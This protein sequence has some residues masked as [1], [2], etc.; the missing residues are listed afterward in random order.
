MSFS[1]TLVWILMLLSPSK[2]GVFTLQ[3]ALTF[4]PSP[5]RYMWSLSLYCICCWSSSQRLF[6]YWLNHSLP[7]TALLAPQSRSVALHVSD[8]RNFSSGGCHNQFGEAWLF[9]RYICCS[10]KYFFWQFCA[11]WFM[12]WQT[13]HFV[14]IP[15]LSRGFLP[16]GFVERFGVDLLFGFTLFGLEGLRFGLTFLL[17]ANYLMF[18]LVQYGFS[19][20]VYRV[21]CNSS[22]VVS[23]SSTKISSWFGSTAS[24]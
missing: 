14:G 9:L 12:L 23:Y 15:Y 8:M 6:T 16:R 2:A 10:H 11:Q 3:V 1:I 4:I 20:W 19:F 21:W 22:W 13:A 5:N 18:L 17:T 24:S 7:Q